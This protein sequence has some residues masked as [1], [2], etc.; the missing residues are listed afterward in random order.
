MVDEKD[1]KILGELIRD[2]RKTIVDIA[3]RLNP[4]APRSRRGS[5]RWWSQG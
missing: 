4:P 1:E 2:G 5:R 3:D